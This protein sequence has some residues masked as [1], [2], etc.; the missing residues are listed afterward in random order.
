MA[1][2][3]SAMYGYLTTGVPR[4]DPAN[5]DLAPSIAACA[6][7]TPSRVNTCTSTSYGCKLR[8]RARMG[9]ISL[10]TMQGLFELSRDVLAAQPCSTLLAS[11]DRHDLFRDD[12]SLDPRAYWDMV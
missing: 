5:E 11:R 10:G 6:A 12:P 8:W 2:A 4:I 1:T 7:P 9:R 3:I